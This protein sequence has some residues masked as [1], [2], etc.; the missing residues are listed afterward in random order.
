LLWRTWAVAG[1]QCGRP[2]ARLGDDECGCDQRAAISLKQFATRD[3]VRIT[4][5][6]S[7]E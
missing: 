5:I 1:F 2:T 3:V 6:G 7:R 4:A